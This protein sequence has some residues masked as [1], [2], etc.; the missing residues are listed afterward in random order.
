[1][2]RIAVLNV[3]ILLA[4]GVAGLLGPTRQS[5]ERFDTAVLDST[6]TQRGVGT[7]VARLVS[8]PAVV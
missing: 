1:M 3:G 2:R 4:A 6:T 5:A 8:Y 7:I